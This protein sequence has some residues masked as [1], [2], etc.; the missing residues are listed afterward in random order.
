M[1]HE[2]PPITVQALPEAARLAREVDATG[3][4]RLV[5]FGGTV[6][7]LAPAHQRHARP[8]KQPTPEAV[9]AALAAAGGW[10][11]LVDPDAFKRQRRELQVDD[12]P[13]R[14]L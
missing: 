13:V 12:T 11:G 9:Q 8:G 5:S 14:A 10:K 4:A 1:A 7:R 2:A 6:V 3:K